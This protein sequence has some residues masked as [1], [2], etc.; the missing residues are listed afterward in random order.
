M[1]AT[2]D[3]HTDAAAVSSEA[4]QSQIQPNGPTT[5]EIFEQLERFDFNDPEF[6]VRTFKLVP[7][8]KSR[9]IQRGGYG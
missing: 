1:E 8:T 3:T 6:T 7:N 5:N 9:L 4:N 2:T